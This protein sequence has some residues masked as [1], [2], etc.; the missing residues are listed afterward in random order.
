MTSQQLFSSNHIPS[1]EMVKVYFSQKE[2]PEQEALDFYQY[3][4]FQQWRNTKGQFYRNW[5]SIAYN[6]VQQAL[7][8]IPEYR[9]RQVH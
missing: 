3:Y 6:W 8:L 9:H 5:K 2:L 1:L 7:K 4:S